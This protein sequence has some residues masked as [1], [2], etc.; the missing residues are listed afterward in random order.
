[1][2]IIE[3]A[4]ILA[5]AAFALLV[6]YLIPVLIQVRK[7]VAEAERLLI[8]MN[9]ELPAL[10]G[11]IHTMSQHVVDLTQQAKISVEHASVLLHA[12][13][14]VGESVQCIHGF[15]KGS[16]GSL[17]TKVAGLV[18]RVVK[19]VNGRSPTSPPVFPLHA[20]VATLGERKSSGKS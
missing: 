18:T 6:G 16:S 12:V 20:A 4:A 9:D 8:N 13:R 1:M 7:T 3:V 14:E 2:T 5:G 11:N 19:V 10:I 17:L 15:V